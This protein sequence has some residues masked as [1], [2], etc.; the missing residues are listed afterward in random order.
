MQPKNVLLIKKLTQNNRKKKVMNKSKKI[1]K[2]TIFSDVYF[3][4]TAQFIKNTMQLTPEA[5]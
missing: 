3:C 5:A 1:T 4:I 2:V